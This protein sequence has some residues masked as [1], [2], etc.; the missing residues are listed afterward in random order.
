MEPSWQPDPAGRHHYR[1]WDGAQWSD[2]VSDDGV[3][4]TDPLPPSSAAPVLPEPVVPTPMP[5]PLPEPTTSF[6][7]PAPD[8]PTTAYGGP[9]PPDETTFPSPDPY[10]GAGSSGGGG[11]SRTGLYIGIA[12]A[13]AVV[14]VGGALLLGGGDGG[15][16]GTGVFEFELAE[17]ESFHTQTLRLEQGEAVRIRVEPSRRLDAVVTLLIDEDTAR[18]ESTVIA[19]ELEDVFSDDD[20]DNIFDQ[21][22]SDARSVFTDGDARREFR[23]MIVSYRF[24]SGFEGEPD[25][26]A[27]V[28]FVD[29]EYTIVVTSVG[30]ASNGDVRM[31][32]EKFD[33]RYEIG[34]DLDNFFDQ[35]YFRDRDFFTDDAPFT[36]DG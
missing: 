32:I 28:S 14:V 26:N 15:S 33:E 25:S 12:A 35:R 2:Q 18:N 23:D 8:A 17:D 19:E 7:A 6:A 27:F 16:G 20:P 3:V 10:A 11:R 24:D 22:Y 1:W 5:T 9:P 29:A 36:P 34:D 30:S 31:V 4:S 13:A 21:Y